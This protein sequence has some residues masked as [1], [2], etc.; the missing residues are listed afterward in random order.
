MEKGDIFTIDN[1]EL[2]SPGDGILYKDLKYFLDKKIALNVKAGSQAKLKHF[3]SD[4]KK[5]IEKKIFDNLNELRW[6]LPARFRDLKELI[7]VCDPRIV[8]FHLSSND[9][10]YDYESLLS[11]MNLSKKRTS[12]SC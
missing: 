3:V 5:S 4:E 6:G 12:Y 7:A 11:S 8:E 2:R 9:I 1:F 10:N